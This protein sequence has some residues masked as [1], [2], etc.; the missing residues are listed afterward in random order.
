MK[1]ILLSLL[2]L[3]LVS[4][5]EKPAPKP[6]IIHTVEH[7]T[8]LSQM[9]SDY[10]LSQEDLKNIQFYTSHDIILYKQNSVDDISI[11]KGTL[12]ID[13]VSDSKEIIIKAM[14]PCLFIRGNDK[15]ITVEFDNNVVLNFVKQSC[16]CATTDKKYYLGAKKWIGKI[17]TL[18]VNGIL[19]QAL[20][21]SGE[22]YLTIDKKSLE[23]DTRES[24][25]LKGK[26]I[27]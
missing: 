11:S 8:F 20:R 21:T 2:S 23:K 25:T 4:C 18:S 19:Y 1:Y 7:S 6:I 15:E 14:T 9:I 17:G 5:A 24:I 13:K 3:F 16:T 12:L 10:S 26:T 27:H 22:A